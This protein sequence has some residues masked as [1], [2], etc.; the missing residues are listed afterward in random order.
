MQRQ[1]PGGVLGKKIYEF[2]AQITDFKALRD[3]GNYSYFFAPH[4]HRCFSV[5]ICTNTSYQYY[6]YYT[7][8]V[9]QAS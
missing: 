1:R 2:E 7:Y 4:F 6:T 8:Q 5:F 3:F 9:I